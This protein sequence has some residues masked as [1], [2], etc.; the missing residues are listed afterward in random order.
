MINVA[1]LRGKIAEKGFSIYGF[2]ER[3]GIERSGFYR[4]LSTAGNFSVKEANLIAAALE[5]TAEEIISIF[6]SSLSHLCDIPD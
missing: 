4:K 2:A 5:L 3:A 1:K 6:F